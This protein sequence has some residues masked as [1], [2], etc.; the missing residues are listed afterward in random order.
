M[1]QGY[2]L[3]DQLFNADRV[4]YLAGLFRA[5][6][7]G[8]DPDFEAR[9]LARFPE[10]E[11]KQRIAWIAENL[12]PVLPGDF[13]AAADMIAA[14][15]PPPLDPTRSDDDFGDFIFAPLGEYAVLQGLEDH[16]ARA[17]DLIEA[18]TQRFSME[19]AIRPF[20]N[21]WPDATFDRLED[22][23]GHDSYHVRRLVSE[24]TRPR[25]PWGIGIT[26]DMA[27]PLPLLD[28]LHA[29][30]ARFVTRSVA[31]HV[32]DISKKDV[33]PVLA[34]LNRWKAAGQQDPAELAWITRHALRDLVKKGHPGAMS[35][36]GYRMEAII[37]G[38]LDLPANARIGET[39]EF[40]VTLT[41]PEDQPVL[42]DYVLHF[43]GPGDR[44]RRK[45]HKLA[46]TELKAGT[47]LT[48]A[49]RHKLPAQSSTYTLHPGPHEIEI[50][51]NGRIRATGVVE[52]TR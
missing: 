44:R 37:T 3:K 41:C 20:I 34:A 15:L 23:A 48:L 28:R 18:L 45:V 43:A 46:V 38:D 6:D 33:R 26:T 39:L 13:P 8:F 5:V 47:P 17:L 29:D 51:V 12:V 21:R 31:N 30:R 9:V 14:A 25:L 50:Q 52:L 40:S 19:Y 42:V 1:A 7:P 24:G 16:P 49:K 2:S 22:W 32:N 36:L 27:R 11:L 10:L 4:G 35:L